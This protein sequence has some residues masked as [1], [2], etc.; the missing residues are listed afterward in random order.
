MDRFWSHFSSFYLFQS[1][2]P[3]NLVPVHFSSPDQIRPPRSIDLD[4]SCW[5][6]SLDGATSRS[7]LIT[8]VF[9]VKRR[10]IWDVNKDLEDLKCVQRF[11]SEFRSSGAINHGPYLILHAKR[12]SPQIPL[13]N[14]SL[15]PNPAW[16]KTHLRCHGSKISIEASG[17]T[18]KPLALIVLP[19]NVF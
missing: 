8:A 17:F 6:S 10:E 7:D 19:Q 13:Q 12:S 14:R 3:R 18:H 2:F 1:V 15:D 9:S 16:I 4:H 11:K 5:K